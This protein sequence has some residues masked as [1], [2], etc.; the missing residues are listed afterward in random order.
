M[1]VNDE[2]RLVEHELRELR[3]EATRNDRRQWRGLWIATTV[4]F[5]LLA[6]LLFWP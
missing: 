6:W 1:V 4:V 3:E 2:R 5:A